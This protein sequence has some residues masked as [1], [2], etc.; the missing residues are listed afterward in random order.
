M[1]VGTKV[2]LLPGRSREVTQDD[3]LILARELNTGSLEQLPYFETSSLS[4]Q[5]VG[6]VFEYIFTQKLSHRTK[7]GGNVA[8]S[9][10]DLQ[11]GKGAS[12]KGGCC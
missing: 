2:D 11:S 9:T 10:V 4:G 1:V 6:N 5:N 8:G 3:A 12:K 7:E